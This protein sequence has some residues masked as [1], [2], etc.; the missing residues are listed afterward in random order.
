MNLGNF[1]TIDTMELITN[2][3]I[4]IEYADSI[5]DEVQIINN[6][7]NEEVFIDSM[8]E[9][10]SND[11]IPK[12][13]RLPIIIIKNGRIK[14][15]K[16]PKCEHRAQKAKCRICTPACVCKHDKV[17]YNCSICTLI[18]KRKRSELN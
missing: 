3:Y 12:P 8:E 9:W 11:F 4:K 17:K 7:F 10:F 13:S 18:R 5:L 16:P 15:N 2:E 1:I 6:N 14:K